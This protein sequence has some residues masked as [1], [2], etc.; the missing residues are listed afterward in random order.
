MIEFDKKILIACP[1]NDRE[2][3]L[4]LYLEHIEMIDYPK[5]LISLYFI[6]NN[7]SDN[8][9]KI[10]KEF[11]DKNKNKY[12]HIKIEIYNSKYNFKDTRETKN[13]IE[14]TFTWLSTLRNKILNECVKRKHDYLFSCDSDIIVRKDIL[15][16]LLSHD[17][18]MV[19]SLIYNGYLFKPEN[20][21][22][23]Y[24]S[25]ENAYKFTNILNKSGIFG[26]KH[27]TNEIIKNPQLIKENNLIEVDFTGAIFL[28]KRKVCE[29]GRYAWDKQGEDEPF[30]KSV[31]QKGYNIYCDISAYSQHMMSKDILEK[32]NNNEL[33]FNNGDIVKKYIEYND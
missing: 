31:K 32:Y 3:I 13:R 16:R 8:S 4:P 25:I 26:Y 1:I 30:C 11:R 17:E 29:V 24:N 21:S 28:A 14:N 22:V 27:I 6:L 23:D 18:D 15:K 12:N 20:E 5:D 2:W 33:K 9:D 7:S 10:L 19:A